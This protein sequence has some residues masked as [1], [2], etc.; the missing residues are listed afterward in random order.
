M[1]FWK[2]L[3]LD[4]GKRAILG[5]DALA[6][7]CHHRWPGNVRELQNALAGL[8]MLA[9]ARG[10]VGARH[11]HQVLTGA[12]ASADDTILP[13]DAARLRWE[14]RTVAGALARRGG[15]RSAAARDLGLTRQ[16]LCKAMKRLGLERESGEGRRGVA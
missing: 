8:A 4:V 7:L 1:S 2:Q 15:R 14:Q 10:R 5:A 13:L 16:G 12:K 11:V 6:A 9:P 3:T